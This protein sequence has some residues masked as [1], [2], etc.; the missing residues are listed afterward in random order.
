MVTLPSYIKIPTGN[1][2]PKL[3]AR[4][5]LDAQDSIERNARIGPA[6]GSSGFLRGTK[7][8]T[9]EVGPDEA[10]PQFSTLKTVKPSPDNPLRMAQVVARAL[11]GVTV[12]AVFDNAI[13]LAC[14]PCLWAV[15]SAAAV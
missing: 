3:G 2:P 12:A 14:M 1:C 5:W 13:A 11:A 9:G 10:A 8:V 7:A 6:W 15:R 4:R